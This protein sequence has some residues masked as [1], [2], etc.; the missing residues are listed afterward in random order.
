MTH[1]NAMIAWDEIA[2]QRSHDHHAME[3]VVD[4][5]RPH[6]YFDYAQVPERLHRSF[7]MMIWDPAR[8]PVDGGPYCPAHDAV[9]ETIVTH[10]I[11]EPRETI[12]ALSV[13]ETA[14]P[15][16]VMFDMGAQLGWFSMLAASCGVNALAFE[17]DSDNALLM[18]KG[19]ELNGW[20]QLL[21]P[22]EIE[23]I[24]EIRQRPLIESFY[25]RIGPETLATDASGFE[26]GIRLAKIDL[27]GAEFEAIRVLWP[28]IE[29]GRLDHMLMEVSPCFADGYPEL[30]Q[31]MIDAG[32]RAYAL[33]EKHQ[34]PWGLDDLP[35]DLDEWRLDGLP[36]LAALIQGVPQQDVWFAR[37]G[38][39][40]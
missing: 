25:G 6:G 14:P 11:W 35:R 23:E 40:W 1:P 16:S 39:S 8:H 28:A 36:D 15:G 37:E 5:S 3:V 19:A 31:R 26:G 34:P 2:C 20:G 4:L 27:E 33:P 18:Q 38:A 17:A 10:R 9:S 32:Y 22:E 12:L 7:A 30:V 29:A 24:K 13:L 21:R